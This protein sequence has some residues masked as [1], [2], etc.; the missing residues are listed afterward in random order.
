MVV[1]GLAGKLPIVELAG[2]RLMITDTIV[3]N[4]NNSL[5]QVLKAKK[6]ASVVLRVISIWSLLTQCIGAPPKVMTYPVLG[7]PESSKV[8]V[9]VCI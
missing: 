3:C 1:V 5:A 2:P 7:V 6:S 9:A 8:T 4:G